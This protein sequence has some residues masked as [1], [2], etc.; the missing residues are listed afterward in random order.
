MGSALTYDKNAIGNQRKAQPLKRLI[1]A[2]NVESNWLRINKNKQWNTLEGTY[3]SFSLWKCGF[4]E[5]ERFHRTIWLLGMV[6]LPWFPEITGTIKVLRYPEFFFPFG[7][8]RMARLQ[9]RTPVCTYGPGFIKCA[10]LH[11][12]VFT[13][14]CFEMCPS[15]IFLWHS[16]TF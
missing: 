14:Q 16:D 13:F 7:G 15:Y 5:L 1:P 6:C 8:G 9:I 3:E 11:V 12:S 10:Y 2:A 4:Y